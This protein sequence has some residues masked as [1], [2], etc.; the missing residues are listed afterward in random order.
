MV[1]S[2]SACPRTGKECFNASPWKECIH[3]TWMKTKMQY[4][5]LYNILKELQVV[6]LLRWLSDLS[7]KEFLTSFL[8]NESCSADMGL[9]FFFLFF[10]LTFPNF[11]SLC[12]THLLT[13]F[14]HSVP[15][16][17]LLCEPVSQ[18]VRNLYW[19]PVPDCCGTD[20]EVKAQSG[21]FG[22]TAGHCVSGSEIQT[23]Q[24]PRKPWKSN[25]M[26]VNALF[27]DHRFLCMLLQQPVCSVP[28]VT[29]LWHIVLDPWSYSLVLFLQYLQLPVIPANT[30]DVLFN[31]LEMCCLG[32]N[33]QITSHLMREQWHYNI[34]SEY[35][36]F[37]VS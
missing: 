37:F 18:W 34:I 35:L 27:K 25:S 6:T 36:R 7:T 29:A 24:F 15:E 21:R 33:F 32:N 26:A 8:E 4:N 22:A 2:K 14:S 20:M 23:R 5:I 9:V 11:I 30:S 16:W 31:F 10:S 28:M 1:L 13:F 12:I 19:L 3:S 17:S